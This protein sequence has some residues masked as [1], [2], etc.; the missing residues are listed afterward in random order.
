MSPAGTIDV[1]RRREGQPAM[2]L[3]SRVMIDP[4]GLQALIDALRGAGYR[5]IGPRVRGGA[6]VLDDVTTTAD[7]PAGW[8]DEQEGGRYRLKRRD[9]NALFGFAAGPQS[10]KRYLFPPRSLLW[11]ARRDGQGFEVLAE[12]APPAVPMAFL[13]VRACELAAIRIQDRVFAGD[14]FSDRGYRERRERVFLVALNCGSPGGTCFCASMGTGP[15]AGPGFDFALTELVDRD[16]HEFCLEVGSDRGEELLAAIP[17]RPAGPEDEAAVHRVLEGAAARMG[18]SLETAGIKELL[19]RSYGSPRWDQVAARCLA[20]GNC[21]MACPTCFCHAVE[22]ASDLEGQTAERWQSWD[23]CFSLDFARVGTGRVR[24]SVL[25]RY[26]QWLTHKL[27]TW[28]DQFGTSGCVGCGRC[29]T[30]CPVG[31]DI[32]EEVRAIRRGEES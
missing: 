30:W 4:G 27:A 1:A 9:D 6:I 23:T 18:R 32:T 3:G 19:Y 31:I 21:T 15:A 2:G 22:D 14:G 28:I 17:S 11:R 10:W 7:L 20:C 16:R 5:V 24:N 26:R 25:S 12:A 29:I 13:G 8:G